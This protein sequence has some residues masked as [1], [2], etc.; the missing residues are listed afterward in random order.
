MEP[1]SLFEW[2]DVLT[3]YVGFLSSFWM[4]GA[5]GFRYGVLPAAVGESREPADGTVARSAASAARGAATI[6]LLGVLGV[7]SLIAGLLE[8]AESKKQTMGEALSA[9]GAPSFA[10]VVLLV[11]L[12]VAFVLASRRVPLG[13]PI[14]AAAGIAFA[15]RTGVH[16]PAPFGK[17]ANP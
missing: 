12:L 5:I 11:A 4:L 15:L 1:K 7:V 8:R 14:A 10:Q 16:R 2:R 9:G 13:W 17:P 6:G 3:Q